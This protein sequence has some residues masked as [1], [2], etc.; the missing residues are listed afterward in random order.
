MFFWYNRC[1]DD[2]NLTYDQNSND[3][4]IANQVI[5]VCAYNAAKKTKGVSRLVHSVGENV[6][7]KI[8]KKEPLTKG[9]KVSQSKNGVNIDVFVIVEY[10]Y[11][12]LTVAWDLQKN[13]KKE[14]EEITEKEVANVNV[15]IQGVDLPIKET[16]Y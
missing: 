7:R 4:T 9:I 8:L 6:T 3:L 11:K 16:I 2:F 5:L 14:V 13:I 15:S 10:G 12:I 1:M